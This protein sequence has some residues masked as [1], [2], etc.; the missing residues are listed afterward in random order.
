MIQS[1][2]IPEIGQVVPPLEFGFCV[3]MK[4]RG[5]CILHSVFAT[6]LQCLLQYPSDRQG[7]QQHGEEMRWERSTPVRLEMRFEEP[8]AGNLGG[9]LPHV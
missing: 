7:E 4:S 5:Q 8:P 6:V 3:A 9:R 2:P 1:S